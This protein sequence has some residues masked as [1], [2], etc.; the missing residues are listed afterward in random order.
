MSV[1]L[2][3]FMTLREIINQIFIWLTAILSLWI[4]TSRSEMYK[5]WS[6]ITLCEAHKTKQP[7]NLWTKEKDKTLN[8][9]LL[10]QIKPE[11]P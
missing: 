5:I 11:I 7:G 2:N 3:S 6:F 9:D 8:E 4:I 10:I 1:T